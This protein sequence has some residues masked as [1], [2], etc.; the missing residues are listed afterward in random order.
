MSTEPTEPSHGLEAARA[1]LQAARAE[2][3]T[4]EATLREALAADE[5]LDK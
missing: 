3:D 1:E 5:E 2:L 4:V